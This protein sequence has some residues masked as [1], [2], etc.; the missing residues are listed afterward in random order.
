M[1]MKHISLFSL[2]FIFSVV[3]SESSLEQEEW[4][5]EAE[6][7]LMSIVT[8]SDNCDD[9]DEKAAKEF[10]DQ[11]KD[12]VKDIEENV[13][14]IEDISQYKL[15]FLR[16]LRLTLDYVVD[17]SHT[18]YVQFSIQAYYDIILAILKENYPDESYSVFQ[19][20]M[21]VPFDWDSL[22]VMIEGFGGEDKAKE[23]IIA[24]KRA[25]NC[26]YFSNLIKEYLDSRN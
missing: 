14:Q 15:S 18:K 9:L 20:Q 1:N 25:S 5:K 23:E 4:R 2:L 8:T 13:D 16:A 21:G 7:V 3:N 22:K 26:K 24:Y 10:I 19:L 11:F 12:Q 17:S 6:S